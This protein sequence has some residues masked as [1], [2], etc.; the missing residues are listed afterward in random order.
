MSDSRAFETA[1]WLDPSV[2]G[3]GALLAGQVMIN[4][5]E[6]FAQKIVNT[7][8]LYNPGSGFSQE[9]RRRWRELKEPRP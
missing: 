5:G 3:K 9:T 4:G 7:T 8:D 6:D 2:V 1:T